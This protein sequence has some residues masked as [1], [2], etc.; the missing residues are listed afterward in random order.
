MLKEL[1]V[2]VVAYNSENLII[3]CLD[4][5]FKFN[6]I[7]D[8]LEVIVVDNSKN[9]SNMFSL[10]KEKYLE[11]IILI[12]NNQNGGYGQGNN[13]GIRAS[14]SEYVVLMNPDVRIEFPIFKKLLGYFKS[15][16]EVGMLGVKIFNMNTSFFLRFES[17]TIFNALMMKFWN[18]ISYFNPNKMYLSGCF[19]MFN[20][21]SFIE[22]GL[23]D[24]NMFLYYEEADIANRIKALGKKIVLH[25]QLKV[26][27]LVEE[28]SYN[29]AY[30]TISF[31][32]LDYYLRKY[33]FSQKR[34]YSNIKR[35]LKLKYLLAFILF[36]R[37][38][39]VEFKSYINICSEFLSKS[40]T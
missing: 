10:I 34:I 17:F 6:D 12:S 37:S 7:G 24:E 33:G 36:N 27:H 28:R 8:S 38:K 16:M 31:E 1:S 40:K 30:V 26:S 9:S 3:D 13:I 2:I 20:K 32:S 29:R 25:K 5:I 35:V 23:F 18:K 39:K 4:S 15:N 11:K 19:L 22:A 14:Q 21:K